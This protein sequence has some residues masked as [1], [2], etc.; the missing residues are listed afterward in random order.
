[1]F[2]PY[3]LNHIHVI[4]LDFVR[5][6]SWNVNEYSQIYR[7]YHCSSVPKNTKETP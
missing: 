3:Q 5:K 1:M 4:Q 7:H 6:Y 2:D